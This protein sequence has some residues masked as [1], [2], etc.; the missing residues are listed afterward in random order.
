MNHDQSE[1]LLDHARSSRWRGTL[2]AATHH[3]LQRNSVCGD[4]VVLDIQL[5]AGMIQEV[6]FRGRGCFI[7]QACASILC[8]RMIRQ[9][10]AEI[11][12]MTLEALLQF[13]PKTLSSLRQQCAALGYDALQKLW[14][15]LDGEMAETKPMM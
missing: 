15:A 10:V 6:R 3:L 8:E 7:S 9:P 13:H 1:E 4:E 12:G 14:N 11:R 2:P 5:D